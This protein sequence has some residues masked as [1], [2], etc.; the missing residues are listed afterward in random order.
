M[1]WTAEEYQERTGLLLL[2][3]HLEQLHASAISLEV[4]AGRGY[5]SATTRRELKALGFSPSQQEVIHEAA[6]SAEP[7][8]ALVVPLWWTDP[9]APILH[10]VRPDR[11]R[12]ASGS[13]KAIKYETP[14]KAG[15]KLDVHPS[16]REALGAAEVPLLITEGA[17][18][19][20]AAATVGLCCVSLLGVNSWRGRNEK[21]GLTALAEWN[22]VHLKGRT[23]YL[24]FDSD[25]MTKE[26]VYLALLNLRAW[27]QSKGADILV[28][29]L[30]SGDLGAKV[31]LDDYLAT[32]ATR[33]DLLALATKQFRHP[34]NVKPDA[35]TW[36]V[37]NYRMD[38]NGTW[39][40]RRE[41]EYRLLAD[42]AAYVERKDVED[43]GDPLHDREGKELLD[44]QRYHL[45]IQ[46]G[47][48]SVRHSVTAAAFHA[49]RWTPEVAQLDLIVAAGSSTRD[50]L[51]E[52]IELVSGEVARKRGLE[53]IPRRIVFVHTGWRKVTARYVFLHA[54]GGI[55]PEGV[56][57]DVAVRLSPQFA[58][59]A[60]PTPPSGDKLV[61]A[62]QASLRFLELGADEIMVPV[63]GAVYRSVLGPADFALHSHGGSG[64]FKSEVMALAQSHFG[65][66]FNSR[67]LALSWTSTGNALEGLLHEA[68]DMAAV[69]DDF[70]PAGLPHAER[71][72]MLQAAARVFRAQ[73]NRQ[74]RSR[75][76][77][78]TSQR[79][80]KVPRGLT[81][82]TGEEIP[83]GLSQIARVWVI[84]QAKDAI[85]ADSL[86]AAQRAADHYARAMAA[87]IRWL[88]PDMGRMSARIRDEVDKLRPVYQTAHPR[89]SEIAANLELGWDRFLTFAEESHAVTAADRA[90]IEARVRAAL[91]RGAVAQSHH[92]RDNNPIEKFLNGLQ[93]ALAA[94][95]AHVTGPLDKLPEHPGSWG[96]RRR[97]V[98]LVGDD[99]RWEPRGDRV[100]WLDGDELYIVPEAAYKASSSMHRDGL[101]IGQ[102]ALDQAL[103]GGG[104]LRG[105]G[106]KKHIPIR[107]PRTVDPI[108]T[109]VLWM[110]RDFATGPLAGDH[111]VENP[112]GP[113]PR[114]HW[115]H[116]DA[117]SGTNPDSQ[118]GPGPNPNSL[119]LLSNNAPGPTGPTGPTQKQDIQ[120]NARE[121]LIDDELWEVGEV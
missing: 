98:S 109:R 92:Q 9:T 29:Y 108:R 4:A 32:A 3:Q 51:R 77:A 106:E 102:I 121:D 94:G 110:H 21:G 117:E 26:P 31:G 15:C 71:D 23:V 93:A 11:T 114:S 97:A 39:V 16:M 1:I 48:R 83:P 24:V 89:T 116:F 115:S 79:P 6:R 113:T 73:G 87:Y 35:E 88:A 95:A 100:G 12:C 119:R 91:L 5:R 63:L 25:V 74:G 70:L 43:D 45:V 99:N 67:E 13:G 46:Q 78:D 68:A 81:L 57:N 34:D 120:K 55:G 20:D 60:L 75:M 52:A 118:I 82:S 8:A 103:R 105:T 7:A 42:F 101:G 96:W 17:K 28:V 44:S 22:D 47:K 38:P 72:R 49:M 90:V 61:A 30:P 62:V 107:A 53:V 65:G 84:E 37:G 66:P 56:V 14:A 58:R 50:F 59:M 54:G 86:T 41:D 69:V 104:Y 19:G 112:S 2:P 80:P 40:Q 33:D 18:K 27:L 76:R 111:A 85:T 36:E 10:Q 64:R